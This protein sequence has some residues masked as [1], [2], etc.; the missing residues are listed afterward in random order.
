MRQ[1]GVRQIVTAAMPAFLI[2]ALTIAVITPWLV[3]NYVVFDQFVFITPALGQNLFLGTYAPWD[4]HWGWSKPPLDRILGNLSEPYDVI[5][6]DR[7]LVRASLQNIARDPGGYLRLC[8][9]KLWGLWRPTPNDKSQIF[10]SNLLLGLAWL[11]HI[12]I[13][14]GFVLVFLSR[15][16]LRNLV[17]C[18]LL[19]LIAIWTLFHTLTNGHPRFFLPVW[20]AVVVC[21]AVGISEWIRR[22]R[23]LSPNLLEDT[24]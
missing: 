17:L 18:S 9:K 24:R 13:V 4:L 1:F 10:G 16:V 14:F 11:G 2:L 5:E 8:A 22:F 23:G 15:A 6:I 19:T 20:P 21:S 12:V 3:R 7:I